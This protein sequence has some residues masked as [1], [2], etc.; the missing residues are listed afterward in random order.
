MGLWSQRKCNK[1]VKGENK[2]QRKSSKSI[3]VGIC[4]AADRAI[5][6]SEGRKRGQGGETG[7]CLLYWV[8]KEP[9]CNLGFERFE[10]DLFAVRRHPK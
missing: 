3:G 10:S 7:K 5:K 8:C 2:V 1:E 9:E 4:T 6:S